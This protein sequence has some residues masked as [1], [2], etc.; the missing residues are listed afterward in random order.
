MRRIILGLIVLLPVAAF[1]QAPGERLP[2]PPDLAAVPTDAFLFARVNI[3]DVWKNDA[4]KDFRS[5]LEKAGAKAIGALDGR[6]T[7]APSTVERVT[8]YVMT[9]NF[10][11]SGPPMF[12]VMI[13][14]NKPFDR[15]KFLQQFDGKMTERKGKAGG[16]F[17]EED[18]GT[19][20]RFLGDTTIA[21][22]T[23]ESIQSMVDAPAS[24][25]AGPMSAAID[26]AVG[27][28][29][30][31]IA[32]NPSSIPDATYEEVLRE[33]PE[34]LRPLMK[35][36]TL[37]LSLDM[38]G[39][40]HLHAK[41][42]YAD[43]TAADAAEKS[44]AFATTMAK[45][46]IGQTRKQLSE[47][48]F[49]DGKAARIEDLP[50]AAASLLG[51]GALQHAEDV[52][53]SQPIKRTGDSLAMSVALPPHAKSLFGMAAM[54]GSM[55][56]PA[57]GKVREAAARAQA[58]NNLKQIGLAMHNYHD[59]YNALPAAAVVD[60]KGKPQLSWRVL[61]LPYIEQDALYKEFKLD[62]PWDSEHNKKLLPKMPK[63][64]ALPG[65]K[66]KPEMTH[67]RVFVGNNAMFDYVQGTKFAQITD[68]LSNTWMVVEA[69]EGVPWTKPDELDFDPKKDLPK[70]GKF[71]GGGF[72]VL[73]AD[74]SVR[75]HRTVPKLAKFYIQ[76]ND[77]MVVS[78]E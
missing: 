37:I 62:E 65:G 1:G 38:E 64:Y 45:D 14:V 56:A 33:I 4:M 43:G 20:I 55:L 27:N 18:G 13:T 41:A 49:G 21:I 10:D 36:R 28:R 59:T 69:E 17:V 12:A 39:D 2:L 77:G 54:S 78:D 42:T 53:T 63:T 34:P 8:A 6:F 75:Y 67:Y 71:F 70:L 30:V 32:V 11:N 5:V 44:V 50:E 25:K 73:Y 29:P 7:P 61:I 74:G 26:L 19:A 66:S 46:L 9:P 47:K 72:N 23:A 15:A 22:G 3:A 51:L 24:N 68:G 35:P 48:V 57:V 16:F 60:K 58:Q 31:V 40:G 76:M 52:L